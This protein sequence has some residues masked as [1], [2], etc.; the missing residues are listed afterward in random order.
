M[1][2]YFGIAILEPG[3]NVPIFL[4][5]VAGHW[6][7]CHSKTIIAG[8]LMTG[9]ANTEFDMES[10]HP[11]MCDIYRTGSNEFSVMDHM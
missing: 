10:A 5:P 4:I 6:R 9:K 8:C 7:A 2:R 1:R 3:S 11:K